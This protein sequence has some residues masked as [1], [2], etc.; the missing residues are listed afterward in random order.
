MLVHFIELKKEKMDPEEAISLYRNLSKICV[1]KMVS[2][3]RQLN[4]PTEKR[5]YGE[6]SLKKLMESL[7]HEFE[8]FDFKDCSKEQLKELGFSDWDD[9]LILAP[10]WALLASKD[11]TEFFSIGGSKNVKGIDSLSFDTRFGSSAY[12]FTISQL[13][14]NKIKTVLE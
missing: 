5:Y 3:F 7:V 10:T 4:I 9:D 11:G 1:D 8:G 12:G 2:H 14:D 13:R 6:D